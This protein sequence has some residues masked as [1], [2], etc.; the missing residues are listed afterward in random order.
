MGRFGVGYSA[1]GQS[2]QGKNACRYQRGT[3][4]V[5]RYAL[6]GRQVRRRREQQGF[7]LR[8]DNLR[9]LRAF[10]RQPGH[11]VRLQRHFHLQ[12]E[13]V[14]HLQRHQ[15]QTGGYGDSCR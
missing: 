12:A 2:R 10:D 4:D 11:T 15:G 1:A 6:V 5:P 8:T 7:Y 3:Q 13:R 14:E 9:L